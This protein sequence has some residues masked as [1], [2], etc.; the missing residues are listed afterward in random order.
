M[1]K[2]AHTAVSF[3]QPGYSDSLNGKAQHTHIPRIWNRNDTTFNNT[4]IDG[5]G[6]LEC[7]ICGQILYDCQS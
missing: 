5:G 3:S 4:M 1:A 6:T 2:S 7:G